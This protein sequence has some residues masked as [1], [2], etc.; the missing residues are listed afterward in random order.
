VVVVGRSRETGEVISGPEILSRGFVYLDHSEELI[1]AATDHVRD[2]LK[3]APDEAPKDLDA[4]QAEI[5]SSLKKFL[6]KRTD[7][8]PMVLPLVMDL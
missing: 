7:R 4:M 1:N 8:R 2:L 6:E 3:V 5:R